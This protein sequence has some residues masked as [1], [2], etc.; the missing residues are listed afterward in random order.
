MHHSFMKIPFLKF[1]F[2]AAKVIPIAGYKEDPETLEKA[3]DQI[4]TELKNGELVCI[5]PEGKITA[6]GKLNAYRP[7]IEKIIERDPVPVIP[8]VLKGLWGSFF[9]RKYGKAASKPSIIVKTIW[10]KISLGIDP[11]W[12]AETVSAS[13]LEE[14]TLTLLEEEREES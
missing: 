9:S 5:F 11:L 12:D 8:M 3:F 1:F 7:G 13:A 2:K 4:S 6:D 14:K 10:S